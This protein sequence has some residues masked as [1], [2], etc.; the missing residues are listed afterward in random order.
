[1]ETET[2]A[3]MVD[4]FILRRWG[5]QMQYSELTRIP[6]MHSWPLCGYVSDYRLWPICIWHTCTLS[7]F[8]YVFFPFTNSS[9]NR[10][11]ILINASH[12]RNYPH[13]CQLTM[14]RFSLSYSVHL[15][16]NRVLFQHPHNGNY[17]TT[18]LLWFEYAVQPTI[19]SLEI[20][21]N[22]V[23]QTL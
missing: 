16:I 23:I 6:V 18:H 2:R 13:G 12:R 10:N 21:Y 22:A 20:S 3:A 11:D 15:P 4:E 19:I 1:M 17:W 8:G 7:A 5:N 9:A 14:H